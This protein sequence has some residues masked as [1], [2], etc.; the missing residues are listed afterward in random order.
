MAELTYTRWRALAN[1]Q[2]CRK[3]EPIRRRVVKSLPF[4]RE[5]PR[6]PL[7]P[8]LRSGRSD[9]HEP[10]GFWPEPLKD[11]DDES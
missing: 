10:M 2:M 1:A 9:Y 6:E 5:P 7:T 4:T 8:G 3:A 11:D